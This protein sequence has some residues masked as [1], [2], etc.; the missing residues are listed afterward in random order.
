MSAGSSAIRG[1]ASRPALEASVDAV[2]RS[3]NGDARAAVRALVIALR[4]LED[5]VAR[6]EPLVSRGYARGARQAAL[7]ADD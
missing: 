4:F 1:Q 6:I 5:E 7:R 3:C 2:I